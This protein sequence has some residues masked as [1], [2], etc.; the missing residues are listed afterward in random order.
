MSSWGGAVHAQTAELKENTIAGEIVVTARLREEPAREVPF[1]VTVL[2]AETLAARRID[3]TQSLFRQIPGLSLTSFDDGRFAYFQLR[4]I[5]PLSQAVSPDDGSVVTYV[6]GVPQ[7]VYASEFA[8]LDLERLEVLRGPQGTLFGRNS[9]GGAINITTRQPGNVVAGGVRI[10]GGE[11]SYGLAQAALSGPIIPGQLAAGFAARVS[12][13]DGFVPNIAPR[14]GKLGDRDSYAG[15]GTL[16]LT[17]GDSGLRFTLTGAVDRQLSDPFYYARGG[18]A[19]DEVQLDPENRVRRT[20]WGVSLKSEVPLGS[21]ALTAITAFNGFNNHQITDDTDGLIYGPLF[22]GLPPAAFLPPTDGSDWRE[23]E[24]RFYQELRVASLPGATF[25]WTIGANYFRST[26]DVELRNLSS[27][28]PFLNGRRQDRQRIDSYAGYG[29][30]TAPVGSRLKLTLGARYTRDDKTLDGT[31]TG[32][33]FPGTTA[34][35]TERTS[36]SFD[37][38]TGRAAATFALTGDVNLYA[39][40]ARGA[41]SGGFP[42]FRLTAAAGIPTLAYR[43]STSWTYEAGIKGRALDG[44]AHFDLAGFW[45]DVTDEQLFTLDFVSF[46]FVPT[47]LDTRSYG[48]EAQGD[49]VLAGGFSVAGGLSWT[50]ARIREADTLSGAQRGNRIPNVAGF[51]ATAALDWRGSEN[52]IAGAQPIVNVSYQ[53]QG[54]RAADVANSFNLPAY[55]NVDARLGLRFGRIEAY[56]FVRNLFNA[57][58]VLNGVLY[59][60]GVEGETV[61]RGRIAGLG[62]SARL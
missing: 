11:D 6:D 14:G 58:Q 22:G 60:P 55:H 46:S 49:V 48:I 17:P 40:V 26:F 57:R 35:A 62:L 51:S 47:N 52:G 13:I 53:F 24:D 45:N 38:W 50:H 5:G 3:D 9:Q 16:V 31:F 10:E 43:A 42:R 19:R 36:R 41:K 34:A 32:N 33:G 61:A 30:I 15:R 4:G 29:E 20:A 8:Y 7:P 21:A 2:E 39:T 59:G 25:A 44:R 18:Q 23:D 54:R 37:L 28:S 56:G 12:T 1:A 27:F